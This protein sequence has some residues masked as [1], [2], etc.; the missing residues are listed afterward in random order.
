MSCVM[1]ANSGWHTEPEKFSCAA[2]LHVPRQVGSKLAIREVTGLGPLDQ[3]LLNLNQWKRR[4]SIA[5][6]LLSKQ[7][8]R[9]GI[10]LRQG[11]T[12]GAH[13]ERLLFSR[14]Q[15]PSLQV[16]RQPLRLNQKITA[17]GRSK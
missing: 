2:L 6:A 11:I 7:A 4:S 15:Q 10:E 8:L 9:I 17:I 1:T 12:R 16:S 3:R 14:N 13:R 5:T